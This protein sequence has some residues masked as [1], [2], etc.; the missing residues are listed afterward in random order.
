MEEDMATQTLDC[1][2]LK[3]PH[4]VLQVR[5]TATRLKAGDLIEVVADCATFEKDL[6]D[7]CA[8]AKRT[9]LWIRQE[10]TAQRAQV[11]L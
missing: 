2:G 9:L 7:Y 3:S 10:G 4:P 11:K 8:Q 1:K 6:R 5:L